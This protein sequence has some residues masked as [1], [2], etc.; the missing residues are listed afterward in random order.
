MRRGD[1]PRRP[2]RRFFRQ[3]AVR[4]ARGLIGATL[5]RV[6]PDGERLAGI[7]VE[8]EAYLGVRDRASHAFEGRRTRRNESMYARGGTAY[9]YFTY[10]MHYC[11]N[12]VCGGEGEPAAVLLRALEPSEGQ[13]RMRE[14]RASGTRRP[15]GHEALCR[16]PGNLARA[17]AVDRS[18]DGVDLCT[19]Q[20]LFVEI[21]S[22]VPASRLRRTPR[23]GV[24]YAGAWAGRRL[25][26]FM[27]D[28]RCVSGR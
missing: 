11:L 21:G 23:V 15:A 20:T 25:R 28:S 6:L 3:D 8:T 22:P 16:G 5:V 10:G 9:V 7:I 18:L 12:V 13:D 27:R 24:G 17:L 1:L 4:V 2:T 14:H 26:W 19:S